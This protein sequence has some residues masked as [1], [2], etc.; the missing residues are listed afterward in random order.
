HAKRQDPNTWTTILTQADFE[1]LSNQLNNS[2]LVRRLF[3]SHVPLRNGQMLKC[4][5]TLAL[6]NKAIADGAENQA[7]QFSIMLTPTLS[8]D[9]RYVTFAFDAELEGA[10]AAEDRELPPALPTAMSM[11]VGDWMMLPFEPRSEDQDWRLV[12]LVKPTHIKRD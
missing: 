7:S 11:P 8:A 3:V 1:R 2:K 6:P 5:E 4:T 9:R 12:A 10:A